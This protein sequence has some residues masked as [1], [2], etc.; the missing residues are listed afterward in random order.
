[1]NKKIDILP[2]SQELEDLTYTNIEIMHLDIKG[3]YKNFKS[4]NIGVNSIYR[5]DQCL[6]VPLDADS[7]LSS[8]IR[9]YFFTNHALKITKDGKQFAAFQSG[10]KFKIIGFRTYKNKACVVAL[11]LPSEGWKEFYK[12]NSSI[13]NQ[14][15]HVAVR[16]FEVQVDNIGEKTFDT[17]DSNNKISYTILNK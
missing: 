11:H 10:D 5:L 14:L 7:E 4:K 15:V 17:P 2:I 6:S 12:D 13:D 1:M 8:V 16:D 9:L 3:E